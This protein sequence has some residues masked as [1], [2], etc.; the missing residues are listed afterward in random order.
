MLVAIGLL[1][2]GFGVFFGAIL[3]AAA[4]R[5]VPKE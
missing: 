5:F 1:F 3:L 4:N 2:M